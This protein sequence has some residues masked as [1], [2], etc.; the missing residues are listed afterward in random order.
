MHSLTRA[1]LPH[2]KGFVWDGGRDLELR[3]QNI[4]EVRKMLFE[5]VRA[6]M[7]PANTIFV[8]VEI[9]KE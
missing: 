1:F 8:T 7:L 2:G 4:A 5:L 9:T 3:H 6:K